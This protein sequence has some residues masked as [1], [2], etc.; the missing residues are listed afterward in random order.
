MEVFCIMKQSKKIKFVTEKDNKKH[1]IIIMG[2]TIVLCLFIIVAARVY[3]SGTPNT[4]KTADNKV[5]AVQEENSSDSENIE[6]TSQQTKKLYENQALEYE[7]ENDVA[8]DEKQAEPNFIFPISAQDADI[9]KE[10]SADEL[11][12]SNTMEDWRLHNGIDISCPMGSE[13]KCAESGTVKSAANDV[14]SG[15]TI[16]VEHTSGYETVYSNLANVDMI[17]TGA[18]VKKG[19][20]IGTVG[21]SSSTE[22]LDAPH[23]HFEM[24]KDGG[25]I[26]PSDYISK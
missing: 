23:L 2:I 17:K 4:V 11:I 18:A 13:V 3:D 9:A 8:A 10:F 21:D 7:K 25:Y 15:Y 19:E 1:G 5:N 26:N 6:N 14:F 24:L 22:L 12:Y 20:I 16:T